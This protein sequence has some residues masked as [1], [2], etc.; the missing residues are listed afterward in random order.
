M[1]TSFLIPKAALGAKSL[2]EVERTW[3]CIYFF[4]EKLKITSFICV[5]VLLL[6]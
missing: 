4:T 6:T 3:Q 1:V 2:P 5:F